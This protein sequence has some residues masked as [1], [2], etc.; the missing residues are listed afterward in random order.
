MKKRTLVFCLVAAMIA[1]MTGC[2]NSG[3]SKTSEPAKENRQSETTA[4]AAGEEAVSGLDGLDPI[5]IAYAHNGSESTMVGQWGLM[6]K[7][8]VEKA[9]NG[10]ITVTM[11]SNAEMGSDSEAIEA[12]LDN[13]IQIAAMQ[14]SPAVAFVPELAVFDLP[15]AF[16]AADANQIA[17]VL[18]D[19][20]FSSK[21]DERCEQ[22]GLTCLGFSQGATFRELSS[23]TK[24]ADTAG[25]AGLNLRVMD[26]AYQIQFWGLMGCNTTPIA[27]SE[28]YM[29]LQ[30]G[31]VDSQENALDTC[32]AMGVAEVQKYIAMTNHSLYTNMMLMSDSYYSALPEAYQQI[33][34]KAIDETVSEMIPIYQEANDQAKKAL[35]DAGM[36]ITEFADD[37]YA[38][39]VTKAQPVYDSVREKI[40]DEI[41][42][43][44][45]NSIQK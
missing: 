36:E 38:E 24:V 10:K 43:A 4:A 5:D 45:L 23:N 30:N 44:L 14:P 16:A 8:K 21:L 19:S 12:V 40:G 13:T 33:I 42:D 18:N 37:Q 17:A 31:L 35:Q 20:E 39:M 32:V 11:Y 28:L 34:T 25:L 3:S 41:V 7:D 2:G 6:F 29:S 1:A 26:N 27:G 22:A 15:C 9:S